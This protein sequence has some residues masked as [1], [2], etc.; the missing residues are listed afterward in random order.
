MAVKKDV[1]LSKEKL[2]DRRTFLIGFV[3]NMRKS[4]SGA[5]TASIGSWST[6]KYLP[7]ARV[8]LSPH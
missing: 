6:K 2:M 7:M 5:S 8:D 1:S 4:W 3:E